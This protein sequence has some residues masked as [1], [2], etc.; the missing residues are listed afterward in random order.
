MKTRMRPAIA[1][2][3]LATSPA[4]SMALVIAAATG[5]QRNDHSTARCAAQARPQNW[6]E[7]NWA[8]QISN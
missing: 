5:W 7:E 2:D 3:E 1:D 8:A 4:I 6:R